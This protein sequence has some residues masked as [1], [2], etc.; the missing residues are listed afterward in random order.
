MTKTDYKKVAVYVS[1]CFAI[2]ALIASAVAYA[3]A[4]S[5]VVAAHCALPW[6]DEGGEVL[7]EQSAKLND[8]ADRT[9]RI[10]I[11]QQYQA[12]SIE[13]GFHAIMEK[14]EGN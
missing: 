4:E 3:N 2:I 13:D 12:H 7:K 1:A 6:H 11:E 14:L 10:E 9:M 5:K 8:I